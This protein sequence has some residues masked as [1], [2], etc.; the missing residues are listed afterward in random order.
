MVASHPREFS[1]LRRHS[2]YLCDRWK[3]YWFDRLLSLTFSPQSENRLLVLCERGHVVEVHRPDPEAERS[4][5]TFELLDLPRR[6]FRFRSIK[7][8]IKVQTEHVALFLCLSPHVTQ[9][10]LVSLNSLLP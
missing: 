3:G 9:V 1:D 2:A 10:F 8:R 4:T 7:S 6:S 5:E